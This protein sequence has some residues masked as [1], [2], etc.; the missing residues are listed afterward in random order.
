MD[1]S[2][3]ARALAE[4]EKVLMGEILAELHEM[5]QSQVA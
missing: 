3:V 4:M 2:T 1:G 5:R